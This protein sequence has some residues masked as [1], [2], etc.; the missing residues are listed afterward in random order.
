MTDLLAEYR[1]IKLWQRMT[2]A[3]LSLALL[4]IGAALARFGLRSYYLTGAEGEAS[5]MWYSAD[6]PRH[7][8]V[9]EEILEAAIF[10]PIL[11]WIGLLVLIV[12]TS[13][14]KR[15]VFVRSWVATLLV[16]GLCAAVLVLLAFGIVSVIDGFSLND[17]WRDLGLPLVF[18]FGFGAAYALTY[19]ILLRR[20]F[21]RP[22]P[23]A[24][25]VF[26]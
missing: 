20:M 8:R 22:P 2:A 11:A 15:H 19:W 1:P 3:A 23:D 12:V 14:W 25:E 9:T 21:V 4:P 26:A 10:S 24:R 17:V 16:G 18:C 5:A 7:I 6:I 13:F